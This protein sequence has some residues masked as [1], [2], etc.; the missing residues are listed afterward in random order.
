MKKCSLDFCDNDLLAKGLCSGHYK[1]HA[2]GI[3]LQELRPKL[4]DG[5][6]PDMCANPTKKCLRTPYSKGLCK[7][8]YESERKKKKKDVEIKSE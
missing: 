1:Q 4:K 6:M 5:Q 7:S 3:D 2:K 8:C